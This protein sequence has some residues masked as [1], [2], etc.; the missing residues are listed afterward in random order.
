MFKKKSDIRRQNGR[1]LDQ[2]EGFLV[3]FH[4]AED[5]IWQFCQVLLNR[6]KDAAAEVDGEP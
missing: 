2:P 6:V 5:F 3:S 4:L 1:T